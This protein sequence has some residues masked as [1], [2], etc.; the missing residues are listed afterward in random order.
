MEDLNLRPPQCQ[1][2]ALTAELIA[3]HVWNCAERIRNN[4]G[5]VNCPLVEKVTVA[6]AFF[7]VRIRTVGEINPRFCLGF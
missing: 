2:G 6:G 4:R 5:F 3:R 1:C 7:I